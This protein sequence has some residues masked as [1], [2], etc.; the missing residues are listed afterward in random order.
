MLA[1]KR[2]AGVT[3]KV[4]H[5]ECVTHIPLPSVN[6]AAHPGFETQMKHHGKSK[7]R[8]SVSSLLKHCGHIFFMQTCR[9]FADVCSVCT[10]GNTIKL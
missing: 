2:S 7:T 8:V 3:P 1:T 4:N 6:K 9:M 5:R 10:I